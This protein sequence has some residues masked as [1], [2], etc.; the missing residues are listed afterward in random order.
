MKQ[1]SVLLLT[2]LLLCTGCGCKEE[3]TI[4]DLFS[5]TDSRPPTLLRVEARYPDTVRFV[6]DEPIKSKKLQFTCDENPISDCTVQTETVV[7]RFSTELNPGKGEVIAAR[8]EDLAGNSTI[9]RME[10]WVQN[11]N[12]PSLL[13]N[14]F[15]TKGTDTNPDRVEL[16]VTSRGNLAGLTLTSGLEQLATDRFIFSDRWVERGTYLVV[17]FSK[18]E[19]DPS[20]YVSENRSGLSSNNGCIA[21]SLSPQWDSPLLDAVV[22]GNHTTSTFEGFGSQDLLDEAT[23]LVERKHWTQVDSKLSIDSTNSTSTRSMCRKQLVDTNSQDDW[24]I[25]DT[26]QASF[27]Y[28]NSTVL[29]Q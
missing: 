5:R 28:Q 9:F 6:F 4:F 29:Y 2:T 14:E 23:L 1:F 7:I 18:G 25:C 21:L 15:T 26:K 13:I 16:L 17:V 20:S 10:V 12:P 8:V 27:G 11:P 3:P 22:W 19:V 24:Y